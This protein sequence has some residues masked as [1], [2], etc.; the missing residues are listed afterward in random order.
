MTERLVFREVNVL[1]G[2]GG[3]PFVADVSVVGEH[4]EHVGSAPAGSTELDGRGLCLSP[5]FVDVHSHDDAAVLEHPAMEFKLAQG[6][7]TVVVGNCGFGLSP[8][9]GAGEPPGNASLFGPNRRRFASVREYLA[10]VDEATPALNVATLVGHHNLLVSVLGE[11]ERAAS[12][13]ERAELRALCAR[14]LDDGAVGLSTGLIYRPGRSA[15]TEEIAELAALCG[16]RG[17]LYTTHLRSESDRLLEAIEEALAIGKSAG[18]AVQISHHKAAGKR[19]WGKTLQTHARF[20]EAA[21]AGVD[22]AFDVY[23][24]TAGSGPLVEYFNPAAPDLELLDVTRLASCPPFP[25]LEGRMLVD[26][27]K[28]EGTDVPTLVAR[29]LAGQ[30]GERTLCITFTMGDEDL[31]R[32]LVHPR[33]MIGSDGLADLTGKPHPRLFGTFPRVLAEYVR[34]RRLLSLPEA[35]RKM[36]RTPC[37]R[38]GLR[39]RGRVEPGMQADLVLF[40]GE[41]VTDVANYDEP[42]RTP[43]GIECVVVNGALAY[44]SG[45]ISRSGRVLRPER[46]RSRDRP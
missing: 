27:A 2:S 32:N 13:A 33:S 7:T 19:N 39:G 22:V 10:A 3:A 31:E 23:P 18:C 35:I 30:G 41:R 28:A 40:D 16:E 4:I 20:A 45:V 15:K 36:T 29:I 21:A 11:G 42:M 43:R 9:T 17:L 44:R 1:D 46:G 6:C 26:I 37:E 24:Y 8:L 34:K 12:A 25:E 38:F 14:A 5:G